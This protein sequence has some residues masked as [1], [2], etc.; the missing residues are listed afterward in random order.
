MKNNFNITLQKIA[1]EVFNEVGE[2]L[3]SY[4]TEEKRVYPRTTIR[5]QGVGVTGKI[6]DSPRDVV[7]SGELRD[8]FKVTDESNNNKV[9]VKIEW[10]A[11]HAELVYMGTSKIPAYPWVHKG[12]RDINFQN[13]FL[14]KIKK[15][16]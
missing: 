14:D 16:D 8:S 9:R 4:I 13:T 6:A 7:D 2:H 3:Q 11:K 1:K 12:L 10:T 15:L 5:R